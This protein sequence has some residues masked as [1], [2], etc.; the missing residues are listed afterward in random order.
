MSA[1]HSHELW[2]SE[3]WS[4]ESHMYFTHMV[5][6]LIVSSNLGRVKRQCPGRA[7]HADRFKVSEV[8]VKRQKRG[9]PCSWH[10]KL[11]NSN[12]CVMANML[13]LS[14]ERQGKVSQRGCH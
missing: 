7:S 4:L 13:G 9:S 10:L 11:S 14:G 1:G 5:L 2:G 3:L 8:E 12:S 6:I